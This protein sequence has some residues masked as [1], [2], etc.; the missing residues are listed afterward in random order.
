MVFFIKLYLNFLHINFL[1]YVKKPQ[2]MEV[3]ILQF[4]EKCS[5]IFFKKATVLNLVL[6]IVIILDL[7]MVLGHMKLYVYYVIT[8]FPVCKYCKIYS[9]LL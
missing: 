9:S 6:V 3:W 7:D 5:V 2:K 1:Q 4:S 8:V